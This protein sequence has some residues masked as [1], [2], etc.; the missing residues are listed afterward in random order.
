MVARCVRGG[1]SSRTLATMGCIA[2]AP[3]RDG[4][5]ARDASPLDPPSHAL[6]T[7]RVA[8]VTSHRAPGVQGAVSRRI[9]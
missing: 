2:L 6:R 7:R 5:T 9:G 4:R 1:S 3:F 8:P